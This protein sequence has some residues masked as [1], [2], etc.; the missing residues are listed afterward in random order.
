MTKEEFLSAFAE[1]A[2]SYQ[3]APEVLR[4]ISNIS[5]CII[6]GPSGA[7]KTALINRAGLDFVP[8]DT[9]RP[10]RLGELDNIDMFFR[11]DYDQILSEIKNGQFVQIAVG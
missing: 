7:G 3:A 8:S 4:Q 10:A 11:T 2:K 9:S 5:L 1:L 6:V